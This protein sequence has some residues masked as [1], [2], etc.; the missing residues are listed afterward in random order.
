MLSRGFS[1]EH[2][3]A[4]MRGAGLYK[5]QNACRSPVLEPAIGD[6]LQWFSP[7]TRRRPTRLF[8]SAIKPA[9]S[10]SKWADRYPQQGVGFL[11]VQRGELGEQ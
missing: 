8:A 10:W 2:R 4:E 1:L 9:L 7:S 5:R 6:T 11:E 3:T